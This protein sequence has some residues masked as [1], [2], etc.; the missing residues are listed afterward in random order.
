MMK[1]NRVK[2]NLTVCS[3]K[4]ARQEAVLIQIEF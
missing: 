1:F 3:P 2:K 4:A